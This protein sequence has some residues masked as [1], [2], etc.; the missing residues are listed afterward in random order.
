M[1]VPCAQDEHELDDTNSL[2][3]DEDGYPFY[4]NT[5]PTSTDGDMSANG[6]P[7]ASPANS[8]RGVLTDS[9]S[10]TPASSATN[11][12][13]FPETS[14]AGRDSR[15]DSLHSSLPEAG[16]TST[17]APPLFQLK[18]GIKCTHVTKGEVTVLRVGTAEDYFNEGRIYIQYRK[19]KRGAKSKTEPATCWVAATELKEPQ[20]PEQQAEERA[21][22]TPTR[23][24]PRIEARVAAQQMRE[25]QRDAAA[26]NLPERAAH[27]RKR[28]LPQKAHAHRR[29]QSNHMTTAPSKVPLAKRLEEFNHPTNNT[30]EICE[31][32]S[33]YAVGGLVL[34][35]RA[36]KAELFNKHSSIKQHCERHGEKVTAYLVRTVQDS[37][38]KDN[39]LAYYKE[40]PCEKMS[41][42]T[43]EEMVY[44][45]RVV[46]TFLFA[47]VPL[48]KTDVFRP[49]LERAGTALTMSQHLRVFIPKIESEEIER[50]LKELFEQYI[51]LAFDGTTRLG[52]AVNITARWCSIDFHIGLRLIDFTTLAKFSL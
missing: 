10:G 29:R 18:E 44:R 51:A 42:C 32:T 38:L 1:L 35:C 48:E 9:V 52:E 20:N 46:E 45:Y 7:F 49:L 21:A 24:S 26:A 3:A 40:H 39:L 23:A 5:L 8:V 2:M 13:E 14:R 37:V 41:D 30:L 28:V 31:S 36:C 27:E 4:V 19:L 25:Q 47:G 6:S 33:A 34:F 15:T 43:G 12:R 11:L 22:S 16:S 50:L 17:A